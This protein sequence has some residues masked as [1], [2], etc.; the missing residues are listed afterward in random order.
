V[1]VGHLAIVGLASKFASALAPA[2][3]TSLAS[4]LASALA[5]A[6]PS[7]L[8]RIGTSSLGCGN[9]GGVRALISV[10]GMTGATRGRLPGRVY[11]VRRLMVLGVAALLVVGIAQLLGGSGGASS[12]P[13][14][15]TTVADTSTPG[16]GAKHHGRHHHHHASAPVTPVAMPSGP[17]A[18]DDI[19]ITPSVPHPIAGG[20]I[21]L[22][23]DIS[24]V[25]TPACN[26][27]LSGST[28]ALRITSGPHLI[29]T[30]V[31]C[32]RT[33][34]TEDLVLRRSDPTRV[35][36]TWNARRSEPGC[37]RLTDWALP[38]TYHLDVA[39]LA[40]Q[41]QEVSF[42]LQ[43]PDPPQ[44]TRTAHPQHHK[45]HRKH[46]HQRPAG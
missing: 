40:G 43:T 20:D 9:R 42:V 11:W 25:T 31:Q 17:C 19:A 41:P 29:W 7:R 46:H 35:E 30:T 3:K 44:I 26:W 5:P 10:A 32:G 1:E 21:S 38:E 37:P 2:Y 28:L 24:T 16:G 14:R 13:D 33:I 18:A 34:P 22:V 36:I 23:L 8:R 15:A 39:A 12:G 4:K 6:V 27:R 45:H